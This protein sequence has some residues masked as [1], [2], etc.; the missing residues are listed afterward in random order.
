MLSPIRT[1]L[2]NH[3]EAIIELSD[4]LSPASKTEIGVPVCSVLSQLL[5]VIFLNDFSSD[6][7]CHY[8]FADDSA[9][10]IQG[11]NESYISKKIYMSCRGI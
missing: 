1:F 4:Y 9:V 8:K 3:R 11:I 2:K 10:L 5:F 6:E 7:P